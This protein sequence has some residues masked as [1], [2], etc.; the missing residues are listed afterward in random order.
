[1]KHL[2]HKTVLVTGGTG[3]WGQELTS[4]LLAMK[5]GPKKIIIYSRGEHRQV[6]M[7][8]KFPNP[9]LKFVIGDVRDKNI[10]NFATR[11]VDIIFHLAALKHV[12]ICEDNPWE[13][14]LT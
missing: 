2:D 4:Q 9:K 8:A 5:P 3:S 12:P 11:K 1:M 14:V 13:A 7:K 6:A 10:L